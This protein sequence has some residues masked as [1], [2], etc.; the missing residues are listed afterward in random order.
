MPPGRPPK[1][2]RGGRQGRCVT[3]KG[4]ISRRRRRDAEDADY[5]DPSSHR[6]K[7]P[8]PPEEESSESEHTPAE[9]G[10]SAVGEDDRSSDSAPDDE[11]EGHDTGQVDFPWNTHEGWERVKEQAAMYFAHI[12]DQGHVCSVCGERRH[13]G[14]DVH[15]D[16]IKHQWRVGVTVSYDLTKVLYPQFPDEKE[17]PEV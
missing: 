7:R 9:D 11:P 3:R 2:P 17:V 14:K 1:N 8:D 15:A 6:Q 5:V 12:K 10:L 13:E 4:A 16:M